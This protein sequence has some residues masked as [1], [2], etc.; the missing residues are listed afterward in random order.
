MKSPTEF[1]E[2]STE[3]AR[4]QAAV[5]AEQA[6]ELTE[7]SQKVM[8]ESTGPLNAGIGKAFQGPLS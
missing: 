5:M 8:R 1:F 6:K 3:H 7:L 2:L 4:K